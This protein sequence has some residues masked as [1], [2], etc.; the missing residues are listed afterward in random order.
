MKIIQHID[1]VVVDILNAR[2]DVT[3]DNIAVVESI[4]AYE[5]I[6]GHDGVLM[7]GENGLYWEHTPHVEPEDISAE[8]ALDIIL[9]GEV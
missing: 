6:D 2:Q 5:P 9:G 8:E 4:P 1:G 7:Y 3:S